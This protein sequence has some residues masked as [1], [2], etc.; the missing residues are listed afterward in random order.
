MTLRE[1]EEH[2]RK[3]LKKVIDEMVSTSSGL[4]AVIKQNLSKLIDI[5][6]QYSGLGKSFQF[7]SNQNLQESINETLGQLRTEI[8]NYIYLKCEKVDEIAQESNNVKADNSEALLIF[9]STKI[10]D[11][12]LENRIEAHVLK[13]TSEIE[14]YVAAGIYKGLNRSQILS[15]YM[16]NIKKPYLAPLLLEAFKKGGFKAERIASKGLTLGKGKYVAAFND[17]KRTARDNIFGAYGQMQQRIWE[18]D[19]GYAGW[20]TYRGSSYP[21]QLCDMET[22]RFHSKEEMYYGYHVG[23]VCVPVPVYKSD[24]VKK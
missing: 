5:S 9:L 2:Y 8:F 19:S 10:A 1:R 13:M 24:L 15:A 14:A 3:Y 7:S 6:L 17:L 23:C 11:L 12:T 21:C 4:E 20:T 22:G 18:R 16:F